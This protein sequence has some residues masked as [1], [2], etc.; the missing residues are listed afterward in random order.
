[1]GYC[2]LPTLWISCYLLATSQTPPYQ[3]LLTAMYVLL[4]THHAL[5]ATHAVPARWIARSCLSLTASC[6]YA[7]SGTCHLLLLHLL[8]CSSRLGRAHDCYPHRALRR[9]MALLPL[10]TPGH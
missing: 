7:S 9:K 5:L 10:A 3:V 4:A 6:D 2:L 8:L 1:M